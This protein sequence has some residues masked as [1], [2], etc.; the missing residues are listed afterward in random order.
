M[1]FHDMKTL[2][3]GQSCTIV[4]K[5][6]IVAGGWRWCHQTIDNRRPIDSIITLMTVWRITGKIIRITIVL[7]T[8]AC[9]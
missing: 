5:R 9:L 8:Y 4:A 2:T 3:I 6:Q 1:V 7:I